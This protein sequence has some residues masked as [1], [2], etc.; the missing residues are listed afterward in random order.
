[1]PFSIRPYPMQSADTY[2][3]CPLLKLPLAYLLGFGSLI[4]LLVLN[5]GPAYA[6]WVE[7]S[8]TTGAEGYT[9]YV[10]PDSIRRKE[11]L[12]KM[13]D[14]KDYKL[15]QRLA[16]TSNFYLSIRRQQQFDCAEERI[17]GLAY[18]WF[19]GNMANG[20]VVDMANSDEGKWSPVAPGTIGRS[21]WEVGCR[22]Q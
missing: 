6:E 14:L 12:V 18:T 17:R 21:M 19:S 4:M 10:D 1:M 8:N 7:I 20:D 9:L 3:A 15:A 16:G 5:S 2:K 22:K 13:W 11:D